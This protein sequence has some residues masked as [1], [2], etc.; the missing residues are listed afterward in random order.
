MVDNI[1]NDDN[2]LQI[3]EA[4]NQNDSDDKDLYNDYSE[5]GWIN[6]FCQ[7]DGNEFFVEISEDFARNPANHVGIYLKNFKMH[8][9]TITSPDSPSDSNLKS[10]E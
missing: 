2:E 1:E 6:W 4:Q 7:N 5:G 8:L 9:E 3:E 10:D